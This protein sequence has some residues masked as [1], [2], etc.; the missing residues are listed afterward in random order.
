MRA[1][2]GYGEPDALLTHVGRPVSDLTDELT[3]VSPELD[4]EVPSFSALSDFPELAAEADLVVRAAL[5]LAS[6]YNA[7]G[8]R[9]LHVPHLFGGILRSGPTARVHAALRAVLGESKPKASDDYLEYLQELMHNRSLQYSDFLAT[10][11]LVTTA[12]PSLPAP[13]EPFIDRERELAEVRTALSEGRHVFI[14]GAPGMGKTALAL[15][16]ASEVGPSFPGGVIYLSGLTSVEAVVREALARSPGVLVLIDDADGL[17]VSRLLKPVSGPAIVVTRKPARAGARRTHIALEPFDR[18]AMQRLLDARV[19]ESVP[20]GDLGQLLPLV[21]GLASAAAIVGTILS[22]GIRAVE[23]AVEW[24]ALLDATRV[25]GAELSQART[26]HAKDWKELEGRYRGRQPHERRLFQAIGLLEDTFAAAQ[27]G[28]GSETDA[29]AAEVVLA[30]L[31]AVGLVTETSDARWS[32][33]E[34][35]RTFARDRLAVEPEPVRNRLVLLAIVARH[36]IGTREREP[37][38]L[39]GF[40]SDE[41]SDVDHIGFRADV[42]ALCSVLIAHKVEPPIS[43][44]LFGEW[45]TGKSTFMRLMRDQIRALQDEWSDR[46]DSPFCRSVK[47]ITFN[48]WN[49]SDANLWASLVTRIFEGLSTSDPEVRDDVAL[50]AEQRAAMVKALVTAKATI[51]EKEAKRDE[52]FGGGASRA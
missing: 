22:W 43:V 44:G 46:D 13:P 40:R 24:R 35:A 7:F 4:I 21:G 9:K 8:D 30:D 52:A 27:A 23:L 12:P 6:S 42:E 10:H 14:T 33:S 38:A 16:V 5:E 19:P 32:L 1:H 31:A 11:P 17:D 37:A 3:R 45:G 26:R 34:S 51:A 29:A 47:Q 49:Y 25:D 48:A 36:G 18:E 50:G 2:P 20:S 28:V 15:R 41:P 39:A